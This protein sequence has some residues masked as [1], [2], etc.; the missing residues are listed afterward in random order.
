MKLITHTNQKGTGP[1]SVSKSTEMMSCFQNP[2]QSTSLP[3]TVQQEVKTVVHP[4]QNTGNFFVSRK[5][6]LAIINLRVERTVLSGL[7]KCRRMVGNDWVVS[8]S[9][10]RLKPATVRYGTQYPLK[11]PMMKVW[12]PVWRCWETV[13]PLKGGT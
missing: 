9:K 1:R 12:S 4:L 6:C 2:N 10:I 5:G 11:I 3:L 13:G 7:R 8:C